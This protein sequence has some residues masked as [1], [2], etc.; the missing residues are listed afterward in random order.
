MQIHTSDVPA[1]EAGRGVSK[2]ILDHEGDT[3][4]LL[5]GGSTIDIIKHIKI[6]HESECRTIFMMGDERW[7]REP[8]QNNCLQLQARYPDHAVTSNLIKTI[9]ATDESLENFAKRINKT[10]QET[11]AELS[12]PKII[13]I[14]G[15]G[16]DGHTASI[17]PLQKKLFKEV[18]RAD[19]TY[20]SVHVDG[21]KIDSRASLTPSWILNQV[22]EVFAYMAGQSKLAI[23]ESLLNESKE[24]YE[25]PA[26]IIKRHQRAHMYTDQVI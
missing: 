24:I 9:P 16:T 20:V 4:C 18:Y 3:M 26:E 13:Y 6:T 25:R 8:A 2:T 5:S 10:F 19:M 15:V 12:N 14:L 11:L 7:S 22:D 1:K 23:L 17:F 21:L